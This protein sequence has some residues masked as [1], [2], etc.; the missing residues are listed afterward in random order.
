MGKRG[1]KPKPKKLMPVFLIPVF[2]AEKTAL[3]DM[4]KVKCTADVKRGQWVFIQDN[5][6]NKHKGRF[7][8]NSGFKIIDDP[9][10]III[11]LENLLGY[12]RFHFKEGHHIADLYIVC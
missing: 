11:L 2:A 3:D 1:P 5:I 8:I 10:N 9:D 7:A 4:V 6:D 12:D